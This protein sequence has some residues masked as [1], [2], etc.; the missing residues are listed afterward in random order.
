MAIVAIVAFYLGPALQMIVH[1][2]L[3]LPPAQRERLAP[4]SLK[5]QYLV[6]GIAADALIGTTLARM[7]P[8]ASRHANR[9][10]PRKVILPEQIGVCSVI[11][12]LFLQCRTKAGAD[13]QK[14]GQ[15]GGGDGKGHGHGGI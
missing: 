2:L 15:S 10:N 12:D 6:I 7:L 13:G 11:S 8:D 14:A 5:G 9:P 4:I 1:A 3:G